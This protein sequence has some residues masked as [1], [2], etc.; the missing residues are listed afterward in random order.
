MVIETTLALSETTTSNTHPQTETSSR[1]QDLRWPGLMGL[2]TL[3]SYLDMSSSTVANLVRNGVLPTP[4]I[5]PTPRLRRWSKDSIDEHIRR[6][7]SRKVDGPSIDDLMAK[8][9]AG[10]RRGS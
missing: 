6:Q 10:I 5:A 9:V 3:A 7:L 8:S 2:G 4:T 1:R